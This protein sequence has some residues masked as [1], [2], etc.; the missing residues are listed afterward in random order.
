MNPEIQQLLERHLAGTRGMTGAI[1]A[2]MD[3]ICHYFTGMQRAAAIRTERSEEEKLQAATDT[4]AAMTSTLAALMNQITAAD[5]SGTA[6]CA[7]IESDEGWTVV[8]RVGQY[9]WISL[10][11]DHTTEL[12]PLVYEATVLADKLGTALDTEL[13]PEIHQ[14]GHEP[15]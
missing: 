8:R 9:S 14:Y 5:D 13:R 15:V 10:L 4:R 2:S 6:K 12:G 11:A 1:V 3:G 7:M